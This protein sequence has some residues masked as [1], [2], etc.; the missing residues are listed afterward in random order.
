MKVKEIQLFVYMDVSSQKY[1]LYNHWAKMY[2][3]SGV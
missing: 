2:Q 3:K 1:G